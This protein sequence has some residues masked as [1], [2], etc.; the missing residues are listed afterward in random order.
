VSWEDISNQTKGKPPLPRH[1]HTMTKSKSF[2]FIK[3]KIVDRLFL[4]F[5]GK[6]DDKLLN[7]IVILDTTKMEW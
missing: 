3:K 1:G 4:I 6:G 7:D 5:G 2:L